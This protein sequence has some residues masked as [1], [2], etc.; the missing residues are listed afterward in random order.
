MFKQ[1]GS[2]GK[3]HFEHRGEPPTAFT[4]SD[5]ES[6][7]KYFECMKTRNRWME[8]G[9][10]RERERETFKQ[11]ERE[12]RVVGLKKG[13]LDTTLSSATPRPPLL[14]FLGNMEVDG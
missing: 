8:G 9:Q 7:T 5:V 12:E 13:R 10:E 2:A 4:L 3:M 1:S 14:H 11:G 6:N